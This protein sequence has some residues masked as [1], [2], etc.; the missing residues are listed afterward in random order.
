MRQAPETIGEPRKNE[1]GVSRRHI[2]IITIPYTKIRAIGQIVPSSLSTLFTVT[3]LA[4]ST[5]ADLV[6][7]LPSS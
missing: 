5:P 2:I 1:D 3:L 7:E 6:P 4:Q